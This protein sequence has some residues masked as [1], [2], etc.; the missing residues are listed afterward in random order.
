MNKLKRRVKKLKKIILAS[1][2]PRRRELLS[3]AGYDFEVITS[4]V[5]ENVNVT[6]AKLLVRELALMKAC[7]VAKK[8]GKNALVIGADTVVSI[9][10]EVLGKPKDWRDA[11]RMLKML[12]GRTHQ[13]YTGIC[14]CDSESGKAVCESVCTDVVFDK[15]SKHQIRK[16]IATREPMDKAGAYAIQGGAAA[17]VK[18]FVGSYDNVVGLDVMTVKKII[19]TEFEQ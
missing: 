18:K 4:D 15:L 6:D 2:S 11:K 3:G 17:F 13:V 12:S 16:Y 5:D 9:N 10:G 8:C 7:D 14:V 1:A 19:E